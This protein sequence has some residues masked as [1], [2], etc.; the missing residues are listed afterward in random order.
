MVVSN[1]LY[2]HPYLEQIPILTNMFQVGWNHQLVF[3]SCFDG[4][5][6]VKTMSNAQ[7]IEGTL[8]FLP[9]EVGTFFLG[10]CFGLQKW[11]TSSIYGGLVG[12]IPENFREIQVGEIFFH[13]A[14]YIWVF[15]KIGVFTP[16]NHEF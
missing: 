1:I 16:P 12:E 9:D 6:A 7:A 10:G 5:K 11:L 2:F 15:P 4:L 13:L 14:R 3:D 8:T